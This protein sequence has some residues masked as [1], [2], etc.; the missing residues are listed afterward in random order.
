ME[1]IMGFL[2]EKKL[3]DKCRGAWFAAVVAVLNVTA[4]LPAGAET[5]ATF[6]RNPANP[7]L[8]GVRIGSEI[9]AKA[10]NAQV[11]HFIPR[12]EAAAE[13]IGLVDEVI[14]NK[15]DA[16]VLAPFDPVAMVPA[17]DKLNA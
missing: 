10:L 12:S 8:R 14:R 9:A 7:I 3:S 15:P 4:L 11:V 16:I 6:T 17:V 2:P 13:Q 5:I 1:D